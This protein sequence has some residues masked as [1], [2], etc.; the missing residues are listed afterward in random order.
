MFTYF[1]Q[2]SYIS[3]YSNLRDAPFDNWGGGGGAGVCGIKLKKKFVATNVRQ[4]KFLVDIDE[5]YVDQKKHQMVTYIIGKAHDKKNIGY[6]IFIKKNCRTFIAKKRLFSC[7]GKK[8][9]CNPQKL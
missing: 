9:V 3:M 4:K 8:N 2:V 6:F 1:K 5:K 7:G